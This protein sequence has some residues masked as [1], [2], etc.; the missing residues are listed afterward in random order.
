MREKLPP[1][2]ALIVSCLHNA[3]GLEVTTLTLLPLGADL[4]ASVYKA[5][6]KNET[7][8][9]IKLK[10]GHQHEMSIAILELLH[11]AGIQQIILPIKTLH[12]QST[13]LIEG[14]TL[15]VYPFIEGENG[16]NHTL[17]GQQ[18]MT[19]GKTLRQV[20]EIDVPVSL[21]K[22]VRKE[23]YSSKWREAVRL[24]YSQIE[25]EP[26]GDEFALQFV[27]VMKEKKALICHLVERAEELGQKLQNQASQFV[28]CHSDIHGGNVLIDK[29]GALYIVDWDEPIMA[30][31]ER[32]LMFIG[33]GVANVWN[34]P[35]EE[36]LFY[37]GYGKCDVQA[38]LLSYYRCERIV[39]DIAHFIPELLLATAKSKNRQETYKHFVDMFESQGVVD[40][41]LNST[42]YNFDERDFP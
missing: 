6:T 11:A 24:F 20:H 34:K 37:E 15:I 39:E 27:K 30:P 31:K 25:A 3:Y 29:D 13:Q 8:Y 42:L 33:G 41:A 16:F 10:C 1:S 2:E 4:N 26:A 17:T 35:H 28:L 12:G 18:W 21:Q 9:F 19:L 23:G 5:Q 40:R 32:D 7:P 36:K 14:H 22:Q 38:A